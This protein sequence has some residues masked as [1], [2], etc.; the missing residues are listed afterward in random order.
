M[1]VKEWT[2][3][4][5]SYE[6]LAVEAEKAGHKETAAEAFHAAAIA[7]CYA[8]QSIAGDTDTR[9]FLHNKLTRCYNKALSY[10]KYPVRRV[11]IPYEGEQ[12]IPGILHLPVKAQR[13]P[14]VLI[15]SGMHM[16]K[17]YI[18]NLHANRFLK[19]ELA[20]LAIDVPGQ[21]ECNTRGIKMTADSHIKAGK[22]AVDYLQQCKELDADRIGILGIAFGSMNSIRICATD[23]RI[24]ACATIIGEYTAKSFW[25]QLSEFPPGIRRMHNYTTGA[26]ND[27]ELKEIMQA[28]SV[29]GCESKI[30]CPILLTHGEFDNLCPVEE[31]YELYEKLRVPKEIRVYEDEMHQMGSA[32][33]QAMD[34]CID[35]L[36]DRLN[37]RKMD[38]NAKRSLIRAT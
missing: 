16:C 10:S 24:K 7:Y 14:C 35:W 27:E 33:D 32:Y 30:K 3:I 25:E 4:A 34:Y 13:T 21:G 36:R 31:A 5:R 26:K 9:S 29:R 1:I 12:R 23:P 11:E 28:I 6:D 15:V 19:R 2:K 38:K 20:T 22:A 17:E 18:P 37:R 8:R